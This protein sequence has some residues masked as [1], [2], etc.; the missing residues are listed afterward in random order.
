MK[1][2]YKTWK[3]LLETPTLDLM[4]ILLKVPENLVGAFS[5]DDE[6]I[7]AIFTDDFIARNE[8]NMTADED[9]RAKVLAIASDVELSGY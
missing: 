9:M 2:A 5:K 3:E 7:M 6:S 1:K 8:A 4:E